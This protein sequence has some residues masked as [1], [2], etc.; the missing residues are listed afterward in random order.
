ML[1][2]FGLAFFLTKQHMSRIFFPTFLMSHVGKMFCSDD[3]VGFRVSKDFRVVFSSLQL[4][5][6]E[7]FTL[8]VAVSFSPSKVTCIRCVSYLY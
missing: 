3:P 8:H 7:I 2:F 5:D 1:F 6:E 4:R